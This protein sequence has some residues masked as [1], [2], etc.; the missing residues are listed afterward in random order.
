MVKLHTLAFTGVKIRDAAAIYSR[1][2]VNKQQ[3]EH[4]KILGQHY[5]T[6]NCL[7]L[8]GVNPPVWT[9]GYAIPYHTD[10]LLEKL[11]FGLGLNSMQGREA[12]HV[13]LPKYVENTCNVKKK[14]E[15]VDC[16]PP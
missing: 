6:A 14:Y 3:V 11:G 5:F 8:S 10:Q 7:L 4:L 15:V 1:V 16:V 13:K 9:V 12:K 2:D